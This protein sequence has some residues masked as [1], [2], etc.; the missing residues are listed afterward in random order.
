L[1]VPTLAP[2]S[3]LIRL[4]ALVAPCVLFRELARRLA[5]AH[6]NW[7]VALLVDF[8]AA[9]LQLF[10]I[11]GLGL[12]GLLTAT[13]A[14]VSI[15]LS[16]AFA[17]GVWLLLNRREFALTQRRFAQDLREH[18]HYGRWLCADRLTSIAYNNA[19]PWLVALLAGLT[20]AGGLAACLSV[21][22]AANPILMGF[23]NT[24]FPRASYSLAVGGIDALRRELAGSTVLFTFVTAIFAM[25]LA[26]CGGT[27]LRLAYGN[28]FA[29]YWPTLN[30][31]GAALLVGML[32]AA[33]DFGLRALAKPALSFV[34]SCVGL[35]VTV[36]IVFI[37]VQTRGTLGAAFGVLAGEA[38]A[39]FICWFAFRRLSSSEAYNRNTNTPCI[40]PS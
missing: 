25:L 11:V 9:L 40:E 5:F 7:T 13:S 14:L 15:A 1:V 39:S 29:T 38:C 19:V 20:A 23:T 33:S 10:G 30:I 12:C 36:A 18:W 31:L 28:E 2:F 6:F 3:P 34:A 27:F 17:G 32:S 37:L 16:T 8:G 4:L 26:F 22:A 24:L 35:T 21:V